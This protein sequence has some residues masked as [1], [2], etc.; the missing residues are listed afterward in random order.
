MKRYVR[1]TKVS[2][3]SYPSYYKDYVIYQEK[4]GMY[5]VCDCI[6]NTIISGPFDSI[7][8]AEYYIDQYLD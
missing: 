7:G 8:D 4:D 2:N 6:Y 5:Y 1:S 3:T